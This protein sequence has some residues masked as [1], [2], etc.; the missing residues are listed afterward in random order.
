[1]PGHETIHQSHHLVVVERR[2]SQ[3]G[4]VQDL[5]GAI[6]PKELRVALEL[7]PHVKIAQCIAT[8]ALVIKQILIELTKEL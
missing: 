3:H 8:D 5:E 2:A 4:R 7:E 6:T 1:V